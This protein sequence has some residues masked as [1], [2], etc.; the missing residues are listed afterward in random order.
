MA[1]FI[2]RIRFEFSLL[3]HIFFFGVTNNCNLNFNSC[4]VT[5]KSEIMTFCSLLATQ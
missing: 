2:Q 3:R 4:N 5:F 1:E